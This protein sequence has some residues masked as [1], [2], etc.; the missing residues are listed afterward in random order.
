MPD[1]SQPDPIRDVAL[2]ANTPAVAKIAT[3]NV[4]SIRARLDRVRAWLQTHR[5]DVVCLQETKVTDDDFPTAE[6]LSLGYSAVTCG[7]RTYN[8]VAILA[9]EPP[10]DVVRGLGDDPEDAQ[11]RFIV[12]TAPTPAGPIRLASVYVPNGGAVGSDKFAYKLRWLA[13]WR[14]W[15]RAHDGGS[16]AA[17]SLL[18]G[19][20]NI[21]PEDRDVHDP[22]MWQGQV[23]CHPDERAGLAAIRDCGYEDLFRR[24]HPDLVAYSWWDYRQLAFP[25]N[26]GLRIDHIYALPVFA[27]A[28]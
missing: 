19:D 25:K 11:C 4:N 1:A 7:Q 24:L 22:L 18:C 26:R 17:P 6:L 3:W 9:R 27:A 21:A 10:R 5:P 16:A 20:F 23:L 13:R 12:A 2:G 28:C 15:L 14:S 8:G